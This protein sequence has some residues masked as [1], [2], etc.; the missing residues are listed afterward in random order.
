MC[1]D[2]H[3]L[4]HTS[5]AAQDIKGDWDESALARVQP[6]PENVHLTRLRTSEA[7]A[8]DGARMGAVMAQRSVQRQPAPAS[9]VAACLEYDE[10]LR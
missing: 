6:V 8:G 4:L 1:I 5:R 10:R 9:L 2:P 7:F 3:C